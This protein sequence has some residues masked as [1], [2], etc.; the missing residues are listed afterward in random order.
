M[1]ATGGNAFLNAQVRRKSRCRH[2]KAATYVKPSNLSYL[3]D[4]SS[5]QQEILDNEGCITY[6]A[7]SRGFLGNALAYAIHWELY[8]NFRGRFSDVTF[9]RIGYMYGTCQLCEKYADG[10]GREIDLSGSAVMMT[11]LFNMS[12]EFAYDSATR[13]GVNISSSVS[14]NVGGAMAT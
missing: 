9:Q 1:D 4:K 3:S 13:R 14:F 6:L 2:A 8:E 10:S 11:W 12:A 5:V 7:E